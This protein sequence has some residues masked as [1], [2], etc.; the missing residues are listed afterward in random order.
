MLNVC[1]G[2]NPAET[3]FAASLFHHDLEGHFSRATD[4]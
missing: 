3:L 4:L 1:A 2:N